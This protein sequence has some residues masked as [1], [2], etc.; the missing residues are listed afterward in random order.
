[1]AAHPSCIPGHTQLAHAAQ[2][3]VALFRRMRHWSICKQSGRTTG[4]LGS[5][6]SP[7]HRRDGT[8]GTPE[9]IYRCYHRWAPP[10]SV[11]TTGRVEQPEDGPRRRRRRHSRDLH[12]S[13][14]GWMEQLADVG[15]IDPAPSGLNDHAFTG[16]GPTRQSDARDSET[17]LVSVAGARAG[18]YFLF[19]ITAHLFM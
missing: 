3:G 10:L 17:L 15:R 7:C 4:R 11:T 16:S 1:M 12:E 14:T 9:L 6:Y 19:E 2:P 13:A 5:T 8:A 18:N